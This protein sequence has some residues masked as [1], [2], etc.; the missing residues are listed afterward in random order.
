MTIQKLM[1]R[2]LKVETDLIME[3]TTFPSALGHNEQLCHATGQMI[4]FTS[5]EA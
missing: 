4:L 2:V 3:W 1:A 5:A